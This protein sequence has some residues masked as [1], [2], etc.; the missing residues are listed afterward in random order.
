[1]HFLGADRF[2]ETGAPQKA[3]A[4]QPGRKILY[5]SLCSWASGEEG[6]I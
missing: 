6:V 1:M 3:P 4:E 2:V 5:R